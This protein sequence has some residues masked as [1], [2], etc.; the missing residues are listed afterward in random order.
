MS[1]FGFKMI[2]CS[3]QLVI[4]AYKRNYFSKNI[5]GI[6]FKK[7]MHLKTQITVTLRGT[8]AHTIKLQ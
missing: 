3:I 1:Y 2:A 7:L 8:K 5:Y 4:L 6:L